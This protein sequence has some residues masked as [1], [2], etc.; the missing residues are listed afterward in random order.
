MLKNGKPRDLELADAVSC[1][2]RRVLDHFLKLNPRA[3]YTVE[4]PS[5]SLLKDRAAVRG[6]PVLET[7]YCAYGMPYKKPTKIWTNLRNVELRTCPTHCF[8]GKAHPLNVRESP[9]GMS[10]KIPACLCFQLAMAAARQLGCAPRATIPLHPSGGRGSA[11]LA[12][13]ASRAQGDL[14]PKAA[15]SWVGEEAETEVWEG[16]DAEEDAEEE[17]GTATSA[18]PPGPTVA[19]PRRAP[20]SKGSPRSSEP[21]LLRPALC[22]A[23]GEDSEEVL[24]YHRNVRRT[25]KAVLCKKCYNRA[26]HQRIAAPAAAYDLVE[27]TEPRLLRQGGHHRRRGAGAVHT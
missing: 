6:L 21:P 12:G 3:V 25:D 5:L 9:P 8:W 7:S 18:A 23:C 26:H 13:P 4:N 2:A 15:A 17:G 20:R 11:A 22:S 1:A 14:E 24:Y 19:R 16:Q 27:E 10:M